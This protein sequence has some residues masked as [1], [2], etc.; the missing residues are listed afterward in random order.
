M[1]GE[2]QPHGDYEM[3][4]YNLQAD[5]SSEIDETP[6]IGVPTG[7][8]E[9][10]QTVQFLD[11]A[12]G[13]IE[14]TGGFDNTVAQVDG[15]EDVP[16]GDFLNRPVQIST[17]V[18]NT[19][20]LTGN[21]TTISPW[22]AFLNNAAVKRKLDNFAFLR[23]R[24]HVKVVVN[25]TPFQ[26]GAMRVT[27]QPV[28]DPANRIRSNAITPLTDLVPHSQLPGFFIYPQANAGG[29][30][31]LPFLYAK[32][33]LDVTSAAEVIAFGKLNYVVYA[34]LQVATAGGST[35]VQVVTYAWM[36][37][38]ELM[39]PTIS[40]SL[41]ADEYN[42]GPISAPATALASLANTLTHVPVIGKFARATEIGSSA[43]ANIARLFGYTNVPVV[44]DIRGFQ[45]MNAP[46][47]ASANI[48]VPAQK[49]TFDPKQEVSI[50]PSI[51]GIGIQD[52]LA[53]SYLK[54]KES[55]FAGTSWSTTDLTGTVLFNMRVNPCQFAT[56]DL[57]NTSAVVVGQR[58]YH[59]PLSYMS[60]LFRAWRGGLK[61]H[62][63]VVCTKFHKGRLRVSFDPRGDIATSA[64]GENLVYTQIVDIGESDD[65]IIEI[66]YHQPTG[67][68]DLVHDVS[69][70]NWS[71]GNAL[72]RR[73]LVD[74]GI[75]TVSVLNTL[76]APASG[77]VVIM[78]FLSGADDFEFANP[79]DHF[80]GDAT[81]S[82]YYPSPL[83]LQADDHTELAPK[84]LSLGI[85]KM[86]NEHRYGMN[87]GEAI[88]SLRT[89]LHRSSLVDQLYFPAQAATVAG[90][91]TK[92]VRIMPNTN[93]YLTGQTA[94]YANKV[95]AASGTAPY[96][97][98]KPHPMKYISLM[99]LGWRG[100][101]TFTMTP[102]DDVREGISNFWVQRTNT[103]LGNTTVYSHS[104]LTLPTTNSERA[105]LLYSPS[106][107]ESGT[108]GM[109]ITSTK[110]NGSI[111]FNLPFYNKYNF[112]YSTPALQRADDGSDTL[113]ARATIVTP[114]Q[115]NGSLEMHV[116]LAT[117]QCAGP[118]FTCL[119]F[120]CCPTLDY[121]K[122]LPVPA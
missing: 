97:F 43:V 36:T 28:S 37:D 54:K 74:N 98:T 21:L 72:A 82:Y 118:D 42:E 70:E 50:D 79:S 102:S 85:P 96:S 32:N 65:I 26:Y 61:L 53:L 1:C 20:A 91:I 41:Q 111:S 23:G 34:P 60:E 31:T 83:A 40:M 93:G 89:I 29:E 12:V 78:F 107:M 17:Q 4:V 9:Q 88:C 44:D 122:V 101:A 25:A 8:L 117:A 112:C 45:P 106:I 87:Y 105:A 2:T 35:S 69:N 99:Y 108:G 75:L 38:V 15:T 62:M 116:G 94:T 6:A 33:W 46:M 109:A 95:I 56:V 100:S 120:M 13:N 103:A 84:T 80:G 119:F 24:L 110:T 19:S 58:V 47:L 39:G 52:E 71:P 76:A 63:K 7:A 14:S 68:L 73:D 18:W 3:V 104:T 86:P 81:G 64:P 77:N 10:S 57:T 114:P 115:P 5:E 22:H 11:N 49:L 30:M 59:T 121:A 92:G 90:L 67:W 51:H 113:V 66:P 16:M 27:Y 55:Y 48:G